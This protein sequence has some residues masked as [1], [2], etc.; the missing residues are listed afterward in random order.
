MQVQDFHARSLS[1]ANALSGFH[2]MKHAV[3]PYEV[4]AAL[5]EAGV[6]FVLVGAYG[7]GGWIKK[8]RATEDVDIIVAAKHHKKAIKS[9]LEAFTHLE[10]D[11]QTVVTRL[12]DQ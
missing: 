6:S 1:K 5:N 7:L 3:S 10:V 9:L 2:H 8:V 4:I 12:R 11:D